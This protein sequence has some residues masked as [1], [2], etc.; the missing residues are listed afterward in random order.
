MTRIQVRV[1][2]RSSRSAILGIIDGVWQVALHA[3]P[4]EGRANREL[5]EILAE[6]LGIPR[7]DLTVVA[8]EKSRDKVIQIEGVSAN[9]VETSLQK[10][11]L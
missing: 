9:Q 3:P 10:K 8:G 6:A 7:S 5:L 1:K 4:Q 11:I 2:P